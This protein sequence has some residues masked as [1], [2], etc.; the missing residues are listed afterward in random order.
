MLNHPLHDR[1]Y[2]IGL[3]YGPLPAGAFWRMFETDPSMQRKP[4]SIRTA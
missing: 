4:L 2:T 3:D 1:L